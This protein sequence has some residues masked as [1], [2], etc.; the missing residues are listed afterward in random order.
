MGRHFSPEAL[1]SDDLLSHF[2]EDLTIEKQ[3]Q[4]NGIHYSKTAGWLTNMDLYET[5]IRE[6]FKNLRCK[7]NN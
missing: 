7:P 2:S 3:W 4:V 6:I 5:E 1:P